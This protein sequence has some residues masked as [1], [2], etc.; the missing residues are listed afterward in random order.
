MKTTVT[1]DDDMATPLKRIQARD[2][3]RPKQIVSQAIREGLKQI[4]SRKR[5]KTA[6]YRKKP[7]SLEQCSVSSL[8]NTAEALAVAERK[9]SR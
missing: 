1:Q 5:R 3:R 8:D 2:K 9:A 7:V 6:R 4:L